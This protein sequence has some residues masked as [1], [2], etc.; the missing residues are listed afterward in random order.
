MR[1]E[2]EVANVGERPV[3]EVMQ[4]YVS[5]LVTS[6]S[7]AEQELKA[8]RIV[9]LAPGETAT[10]AIELPVADCTIVDAE[11]RRIVEPGEFEL[12]VGRSSRDP[13][14]LRTRF[15]VAG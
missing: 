5:D 1:A 10:V 6:V 15:T 11:G 8:F 13:D 14:T 7:W 12:R 3:R 4:A 9:E 2:L